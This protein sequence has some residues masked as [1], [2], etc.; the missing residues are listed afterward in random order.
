MGSKAQ[1]T[2]F[3]VLAG[4]AQ[5]LADISG[6]VILPYFRKST[7]VEN[8]GKDK[9][10]DPVTKA[11]QGAERAIAKAIAA[12]FPDHSLFGEEYGSTAGDSPYR[13]VID[14]ID[15]TRAFIMGSPLWGTLIGLLEDNEPLLGVADHPFTAERFW[16]AEKA[17]F[18]RMGDA[19]PKRL[20]TRVCAKLADAVITTTHPELFEDDLQRAALDAVK[21]GARMSRY[22]G[23]CYN[24]CLL[25][26]GF[27]D[28]W[29]EPNLK[30][31]DIA[32]LIP[33]IERAGGRVT[34]W[35]GKSAA[36]GG[37]VL[38]T[39]DPRLHQTLLK[40]IAGL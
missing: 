34:T 11:D 26:A 20:I 19:K 14:P 24:G 37:N 1:K 15:G 21:G 23:D 8:K 30:P 29:I 36:N 5:T 27:V 31:Y 16:S 25:A 3:K 7:A 10:F 28:V 17:S 6:R 12:R 40:L 2:P 32:A 35:D 22:G 38:A 9:T 18:M 39:G 13:W 33:I 4:F